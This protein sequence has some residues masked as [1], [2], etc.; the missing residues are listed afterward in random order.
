M[1]PSDARLR[2]LEANAHLPEVQEQIRRE[3]VKGTMRV[4]P[5][6]SGGIRLIPVSPDDKQGQRQGDPG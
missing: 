5:T 2:W 3:V 6:R 4:I 1:R